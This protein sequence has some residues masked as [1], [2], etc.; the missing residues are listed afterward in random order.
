MVL[1]LALVGA[2]ALLTRGAVF[3]LPRILPLF[4][5]VV[6]KVIS[7][8]IKTIGITS[9][10]LVST[11]VLLE[12]PIIRKKVVEAPRSALEFGKKVGRGVEKPEKNGVT[13][14]EGLKKAGIAGGIIAAVVG[15]AKIIK[16]KKAKV[17]K[18]V[19]PE[20][21]MPTPF[22]LTPDTQPVGAVKKP[23]E[24]P[25]VKPQKPVTIKNTF[26]PTIAV[27]FSESRKFINQQ[28]LV[29]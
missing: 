3:V 25:A 6:G 1:P 27:R 26:N 8:P 5:K 16:D 15:G 19:I 21:I 24:V 4:G 10:G 17:P 23:A 9:L 18:T 29:K 20:A 7:S 14:S 11:G 22:V 13:I 2:A 12:S 28:I